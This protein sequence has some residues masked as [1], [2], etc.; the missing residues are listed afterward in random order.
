MVET[1]GRSA[2]NATLNLVLGQQVAVVGQLAGGNIKMADGSYKN[3]TVI[4]SHCI[5]YLT[6][7][8]RD[9]DA[10]QSA[11]NFEDGFDDIE[12]FGDPTFQYTIIPRTARSRFFLRRARSRT[13][14]K[15]DASRRN[16]K[17]AFKK[18]ETL[19]TGKPIVIFNGH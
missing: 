4:V 16:R 10:C 3:C 5:E 14:K 1:F 15:S 6:K 9:R 17:D 2:L 18:Q 13:E 7:P 12:M 8:K 11:T 19:E